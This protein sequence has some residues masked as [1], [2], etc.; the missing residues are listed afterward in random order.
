[1]IVDWRVSSCSY[2][3]SYLYHLCLA[4]CWDQFI[5]LEVVRAPFCA[6]HCFELT[7]IFEAGHKM[8]FHNCDNSNWGQA[9]DQDSFCL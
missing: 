8:L 9:T 1:M 2:D 6:L 5:E 7:A 3:N 4:I